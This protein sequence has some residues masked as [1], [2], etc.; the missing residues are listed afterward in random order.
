[1]DVSIKDIGDFIGGI[2]FPAFIAIFV[3]MRLEPAVKRLEKA[4]TTLM[5]VTAKSNGMG[6]K[7]VA[8]IVK[9]VTKDHHHRRAGDK[10]DS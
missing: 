9:A 8:E 7:E 3:L 4:I 2:G 6:G 1:M 10:I 5:V